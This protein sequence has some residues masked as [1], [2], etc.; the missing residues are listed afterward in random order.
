MYGLFTTIKLIHFKIQI[1]TSLFCM[2]HG[3]DYFHS[4]KRKYRKIGA[5]PMPQVNCR[6]SQLITQQLEDT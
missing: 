4:D 2:I 6:K 3:K 5:L 1:F